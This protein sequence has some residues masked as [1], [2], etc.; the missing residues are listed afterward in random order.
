[1]ELAGESKDSIIK[2]FAS[3]MKRWILLSQCRFFIHFCRL[4]KNLINLSN[5][6]N[7]MSDHN[8]DMS[9]DIMT[10][11]SSN[12]NVNVCQDYITL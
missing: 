1:M 10:G 3:Q 11:Q 8:T 4:S 6:N 2:I 7:G 5:N 12:N 9:D